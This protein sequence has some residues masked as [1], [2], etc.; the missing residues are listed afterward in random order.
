MTRTKRG[1]LVTVL[2]LR[3]YEFIRQKFS[4]HFVQK[5][6]AST[7]IMRGEAGLPRRVTPI[8]GPGTRVSE[9]LGLREDRL[10]V[11]EASAAARLGRPCQ[12]QSKNSNARQNSE[13]S[14]F[15]VKFCLQESLSLG[16]SHT[17][18]KSA[19][20]FLLELLSYCSPKKIAIS[21]EVTF[22]NVSG[23]VSP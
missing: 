14:N 13:T 23:T 21:R 1:K 22:G 5:P 10:G 12:S 3:S 4:L 16:L 2:G 19:C 11:G 6:A 9:R 17:V 18:H 15:D 20:K 8:G 7:G